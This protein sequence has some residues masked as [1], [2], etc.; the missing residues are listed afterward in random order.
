MRVVSA[1]LCAGVLILASTQFGAAQRAMKQIINAGPPSRSPLSAAVK[2]GGLVYVSGQYGQDMKGTLV[3][4]IK[5]QTKQALDNIDTILKTA[6]S[7]LAN[8]ANVTVYLKNIGDFAAMN[9]V[10]APRWPKDP[11]A[12]T[13]VSGP[14]ANPDALIEIVAVGIVNGGE[15]VAVNPDGWLKTNPYSYAIKSGN[16]LFMSGLLSRD[17]K[18]NSPVKGEMPAQTKTALE[19]AGAVLKAAGMSYDD[20]AAVRVFITDVAKFQDMNGAYRPFFT[21]GKLPARATVRVAL[22][23]PDYQVEIAMV[24]V[25]DPGRTAITAPNADGTPGTPGPNFSS[26]IKAGNRLFVAGMLGTTESNKGDIKAQTAEALTRLGRA[27]KAGGYDWNDVVDVNVFMPD[28]TKFADMNEEYR[29]VFATAPPA[30]ATLGAGLVA[31]GLVEIMMTA[32]K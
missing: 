10:Y 30:R 28:L 22:P 31:D 32:V 2:A 24:A 5:G 3:G 6:G 1:L 21:A 8:T 12:R 19:N 25:K 18:D 15:R 17:G 4:D 9:E 26:A 27:V 29:K 14:L 13:T 11:P 7:G 23:G 20:V 16:T